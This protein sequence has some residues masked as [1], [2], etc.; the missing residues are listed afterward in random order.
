MNST[1]FVRFCALLSFVGILFPWNGKGE[2]AL[3]IEA[4]MILLWIHMEYTS[5]KE[6]SKNK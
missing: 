3:I 5:Y 4:L 2:I 6:R 1:N